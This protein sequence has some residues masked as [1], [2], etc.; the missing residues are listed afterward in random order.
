MKIAVLF[1]TPAVGW[2]DE[3]FYAKWFG[4]DDPETVRGLKGPCLNMMS[5]QSEFAPALLEKMSLILD[6]EYIER[7]KRHY[8]MFKEAVRKER[9]GG[10]GKRRKKRR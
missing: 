4:D 7:L 9:S 8:K 6:E 3:D 5:P 10:Q 1:D 2:E